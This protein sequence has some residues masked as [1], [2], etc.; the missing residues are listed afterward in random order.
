[1]YILLITTSKH[2][3]DIENVYTIRTDV[4]REA[5]LVSFDK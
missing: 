4:K 3:T 2:P 1:M 5:K